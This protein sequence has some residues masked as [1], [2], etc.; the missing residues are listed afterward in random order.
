MPTTIFG[1]EPVVIIGI[2]ASCVIAVVQVLSGNG[3]ISDVAAGKAIDATNAMAQIIT[4][5]APAIAALIARP[6][7]TPVASPALP[8]GTKVTVITPPANPNTTTTV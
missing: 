5:L 2:A 3:V 6:Q 8:Q 7:V 1:K 4:I